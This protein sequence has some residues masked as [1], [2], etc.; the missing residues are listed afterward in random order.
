M[1]EHAKLAATGG[2]IIERMCAEVDSE[3]VLF[4]LG[5]R[6]NRPW[7]FWRWLPVARAMPRMQAELAARPELGLLHARNHFGLQTSLSVQY[8]RSLED[9]L[10]FAK[11]P[12]QT[13]F[14]A[15][16]D[17]YRRLGGSADV[18]IWH[19]T[20]L[21]GPG[22]QEAIYAAMPPFGLG[23]GGRLVPAR[24]RRNGAA[25]RMAQGAG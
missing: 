21:I 1:T 7:K 3:M 10:A 24:G 2:I 22:R 6:L 12:E 19:E 17:F 16:R 8:W 23:R 4:L 15:W 20:Y 13:H 5:M 9:L 18:G 25:A 14:P 11:A